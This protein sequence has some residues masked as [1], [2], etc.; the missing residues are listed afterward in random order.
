M[1]SLTHL[2]GQLAADSGQPR[3]Q[4]LKATAAPDHEHSDGPLAELI[5]V[6]LGSTS[7]S[8]SRV[9]SGTSTSDVSGRPP[10]TPVESAWPT[11]PDSSI[12]ENSAK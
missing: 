12:K 9:I 6:D 7:A 11:A 8:A 2:S 5:A 10:I 4:A 3:R 1:N